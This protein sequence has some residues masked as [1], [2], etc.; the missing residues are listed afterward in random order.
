M[1]LSKIS[2]I[3]C[4]ACRLCGIEEAIVLK[5]AVETEVL[6]NLR[7]VDTTIGEVEVATLLVGGIGQARPFAEGVTGLSAVLRLG[8]HMGVVNPY[9]CYDAVV[10]YF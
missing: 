8:I 9:L 3:V 6:V 5:H 4:W 2:V 10:Y 7:P 1:C